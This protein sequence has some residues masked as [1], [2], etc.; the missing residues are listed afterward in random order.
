MIPRI[1]PKCLVCKNPDVR[2]G[3]ELMWNDGMT[4]SAII[5]VVGDKLTTPAI[6]RHLKEHTDG[7]A[8]AR[9]IEVAPELPAR[10]RVLALQQMQLDEMERRIGLAQNR[11]AIVNAEHEGEPDW[12]PVDWAQ[13]HDI[14]GKDMQAAI[15]SILKTQGLTD[16]RDKAQGDLKLG[17]FEAMTAAG[18]APKSISGGK[19]PVLH[20]EG[21][22]TPNSED[23][24]QERDS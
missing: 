13:F 14:L 24:W 2:R 15:G 7:N 22:D 6:T 16:K 1:D 17:L 23:D 11:A 12:E 4:Q 5:R 20:T 10:E 9:R 18:L 3:V 8:N 19:M 21:E